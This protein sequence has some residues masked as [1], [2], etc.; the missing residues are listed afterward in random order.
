[1]IVLKMNISVV[2]A[3][4]PAH[5]KIEAKSRQTGEGNGLYM[6]SSKRTYT[7]SRGDFV[8]QRCEVVCLHSNE[9]L[10][11]KWELETAGYYTRQL[12]LEMARKS[13]FQ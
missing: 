11:K 12:I 7:G 2:V 9:V 1:M 10:A 4:V 13:Y 3:W 5:D 6:T 8:P